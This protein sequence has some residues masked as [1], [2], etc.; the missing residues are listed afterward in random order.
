G[1]CCIGSVK[2]NFGHLSCAAGTAGLI[3]TVLAI[4]HGAIP[5]TL[6]YKAPNP[7]I[8]LASSPFYV[9]TRLRPWGRH[10]AP[11][12]AGGLLVGGGR[13]SV[14]SAWVGPMPTWWWRRRRQRRRRLSA[15]RISSL[16]SR[17]EATRP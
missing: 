5:P 13:A 1:F 9:T 3:K 6:H 12:P 15:A 10:G 14:R 17:R 8:D 11:R 2:S 7:A 16:C 4:E